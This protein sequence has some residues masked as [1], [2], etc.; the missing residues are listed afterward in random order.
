MV[1]EETTSEFN[2][3]GSA[4]KAA[5]AY[6]IDVSLLENNMHLTPLERIRIHGRA[7]N[8][9]LMLRDAVSEQR[10]RS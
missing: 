5:R 2:P 9:A 1:A 6:G 8:E 3:E 7:L 10:A 4:W